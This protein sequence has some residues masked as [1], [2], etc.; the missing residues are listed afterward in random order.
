MLKRLKNKEHISEVLNSINN[1]MN[2]AES[3]LNYSKYMISRRAFQAGK[4][5]QKVIKLSPTDY[6]ISSA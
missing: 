2:L 1:R 4:E 6:D 3:L 5:T